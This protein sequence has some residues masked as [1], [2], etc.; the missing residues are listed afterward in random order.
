MAVYLSKGNPTMRNFRYL[1]PALIAMLAISPSTHG[2]DG[3]GATFPKC[4]LIIRHG[5][6]A[7]PANAGIHL[8]DAG[9]ARAKKLHEL[10]TNST[11]QPKLWP[12]PDFIFAARNT[13]IS[14]RPL[15]TVAPFAASLKLKVNQDF[16]S[17]PKGAAGLAE[18]LFRN[19]AY[20]GKTILIAW[21]HGN[22][23]ELAKAL[24]ATNAPTKWADE[25]FDRVWQITY[26]ERGAATFVN[27]PQNLM[28]GDAPK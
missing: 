3:K 25:V 27:L 22:L 7:V 10:F 14:H 17:V 4:I 20:Q 1:T 2:Q 24:K 11:A 19:P 28:P 8:N 5:E 15:E 18:E 12:M 21:R 6:K 13:E 26:D 23:P 9:Q 16:H